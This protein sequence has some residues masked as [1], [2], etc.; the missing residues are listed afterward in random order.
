MHFTVSKNVCVGAS[1]SLGPSLDLSSDDPITVS[2]LK[3]RSLA[4]LPKNT[5][6]FI[7]SKDQLNF[8]Q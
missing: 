2:I 7:L 8:L 1:I 5:N 6:I 3:Q 4:S